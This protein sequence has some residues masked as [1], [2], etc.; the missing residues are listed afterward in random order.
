MSSRTSILTVNLS[1][2]EEYESLIDRVLEVATLLLTVHL[3]IHLAPPAQ[4][5][6]FAANFWQMVL[7]TAI[8]LCAYTLVVKRL[9]RFKCNPGQTDQ[10]PFHLLR[11]WLK[12]KL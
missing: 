7:F 8:G 12:N 10:N 2:D 6:L 1:L 9:I 4:T 11:L 5:G 3:L